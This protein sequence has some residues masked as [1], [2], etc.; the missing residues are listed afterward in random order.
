MPS[1][2]KVKV[3]V[4]HNLELVANLKEAVSQEHNHPRLDGDSRQDQHTIIPLDDPTCFCIRCCAIRVVNSAT[5][6]DLQP[7]L[8][9][10]LRLLA[11]KYHP[12]SNSGGLNECKHGYAGGIPCPKCDRELLGIKL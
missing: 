6:N 3:D 5:P 2:I 8:D 1:P 12:W 9:A 11:D 10:A 7:K 4:S